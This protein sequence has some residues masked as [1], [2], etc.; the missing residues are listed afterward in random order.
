LGAKVGK[1]HSKV[2]ANY[3]IGVDDRFS[4]ADGKLFP[5]PWE[6]DVTMMAT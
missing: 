6:F 1:V 3:W 5:L 4:L 2:I